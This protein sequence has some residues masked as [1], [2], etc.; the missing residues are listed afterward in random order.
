MIC[1]TI[2]LPESH[3]KANDRSHLCRR[4]FCIVCG[5][6][7]YNWGKIGIMMVIIRIWVHQHC[8]ASHYTNNWQG[9]WRQKMKKP[10][11]YWCNRYVFLKIVN[12]Q[13]QPYQWISA[14]KFPL[15]CRWGQEKKPC[16]FL[17]QAEPQQAWHR[18]FLHKLKKVLK[19][20]K[21]LVPKSS[22]NSD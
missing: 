20:L 2:Y 18:R 14:L 22:K 10:V 5:H 6:L 12:Y 1:W 9:S 4:Q 3:N 8:L 7:W 11:K 17:S 16:R 15:S 21:E 13:A 19:V